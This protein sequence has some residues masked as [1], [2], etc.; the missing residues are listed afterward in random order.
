M[1]PFV[2]FSKKIDGARCLSRCSR[3][4]SKTTIAPSIH[5]PYIHDTVARVEV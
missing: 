1:D 4:G 2:P 3:V 5:Y